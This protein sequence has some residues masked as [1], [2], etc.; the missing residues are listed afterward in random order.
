MREKRKEEGEDEDEDEDKYKDE[1]KG[2]S[3]NKIFEQKKNFFF[4]KRQ[5]LIF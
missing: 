2:E 3:P 5:N 4:N 1:K